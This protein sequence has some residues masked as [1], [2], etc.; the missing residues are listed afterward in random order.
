[1][2]RV[3]SRPHRGYGDG[4]VS[5]TLPYGAS[6]A[7]WSF[8]AR[9]SFRAPAK[10]AA[11]FVAHPDW[12]CPRV[13][14]GA[15][16]RAEAVAVATRGFSEAGEHS[17]KPVPAA[18]ETILGVGRNDDLAGSAALRVASEWGRPEARRQERRGRGKGSG[19]WQGGDGTTGERADGRW[20]SHNPS[21]HTRR[22]PRRP[23]KIKSPPIVSPRAQP[24]A[25]GCRL[26][27]SGGPPFSSPGRKRSGRGRG[28]R[29]AIGLGTLARR[30]GAAGL[31]CSLAAPL[32]NFRG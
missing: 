20:L 5:A 13:G 23:P 28:W 26:R 17:L 27:R 16:R 25:R 12:A 8:L 22:L 9:P 21:L 30:C 18:A 19:D 7:G 4:L 1:M 14:I 29:D 31:S 6:A 32:R 24:V 15:T 10:A 2:I 11:I 3:C